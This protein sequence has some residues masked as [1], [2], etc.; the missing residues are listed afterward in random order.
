MTGKQPDAT[1]PEW[2]LELAALQ[3]SLR[4][5]RALV[6]TFL[7][8]L[9]KANDDPQGYVQELNAFS[10]RIASDLVVQLWKDRPLSDAELH[11][12]VAAIHTEHAAVIEG[13]VQGVREPD[14]DPKPPGSK[15]PPI[16]LVS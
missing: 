13:L 5:Q 3:G 7:K 2:K 10:G 11:R 1:P 4:L 6:V 14:P 16:R 8:I 12:M 9:A 15:R